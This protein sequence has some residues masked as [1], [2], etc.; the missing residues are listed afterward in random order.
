[1]AVCYLNMDN[2]FTQAPEETTPVETSVEQNTETTTPS[3]ANPS[4]EE[5]Q[6]SE[7]QITTAQRNN[8]NA[9]RRIRSR[10]AMSRRI[11]ELEAEIDRLKGKD[12]DYSKF[13][14]GQLTDRIDD[15][16][17]IQADDETNAF[18]ENAQQWFGDD[19]QKFL[20]DT[21]RYANYVNNNE[22]DLLNY[23]QREYGPILLHE[24]YKRMDNPQLR[25]QW[26]Q[27]TRYEKN[28][29]LHRYYTDISKI[30]NAVNSGAFRQPGAKP[31]PKDVPIPG[32]GRQ[33]PSSEPSDDFGV[34]L[35]RAMG[36]HSSRR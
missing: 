3:E 1:M 28:M 8:A 20:Q 35:Q 36:R 13:R 23:A 26:M 22:P 18:I 14:T 2:E 4:G 5:Q 16:R 7:E 27:M 21:S 6:G 10:N 30:V 25:E 9:Q 24:W 12:D 33:T 31:T 32:S 34:E 11:A 15:M 17:A 19:T 29:V